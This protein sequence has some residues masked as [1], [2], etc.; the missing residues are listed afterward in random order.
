MKDV[1]NN[2]NPILHERALRMGLTATK[3]NNIYCWGN[4]KIDLTASGNEDWQI[5]KNMLAQS[6]NGKFH[7]SPNKDLS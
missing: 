2:F 3:E 5:S 4:E 1:K 6:K 7:K